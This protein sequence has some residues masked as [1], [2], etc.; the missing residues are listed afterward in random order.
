MRD[1][2][3]LLL[4]RIGKLI[5][6]LIYECYQPHTLAETKEYIEFML[7][8]RKILPNLSDPSECAG[9]DPA[10]DFDFAKDSAPSGRLG[11][12]LRLESEKRKGMLARLRRI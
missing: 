5:G 10:R 12:Y 9:S 7:T 8:R 2:S 11:E 6:R 3:F 4:A 1:V